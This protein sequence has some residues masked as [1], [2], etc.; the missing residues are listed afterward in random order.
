MRDVRSRLASSP[1]NS[2]LAE[3][4]QKE[5][6]AALSRLP[7]LLRGAIRRLR[8]RNWKGRPVRESEVEAFRVE[9]GFSRD[10]NA[11]VLYRNY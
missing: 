4:P 8:L 10:P 9:L 3:L 2:A 5:L 7:E 1:H 6:K 11:L